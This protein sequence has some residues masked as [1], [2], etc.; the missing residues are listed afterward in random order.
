M[1]IALKITSET[2]Q[3]FWILFA[4]IEQGLY[5]FQAWFIN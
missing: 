3:A 1:E 4:G 5:L 2:R